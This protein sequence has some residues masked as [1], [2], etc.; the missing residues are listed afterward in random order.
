MTPVEWYYARGNKQMGPVSAPELKRLAT[1]GELR[2]ED[3]V[4][5]E[6]M[7]EW[8][9]ARNVR[10][11]F[12]EEGKPAAAVAG[13]AAAKAGES[14]LK[15][16][17]P[18]PQPPEAAAAAA[19]QGGA[20]GASSLR[21][22]AGRGPAAFQRPL[23]RGH[24]QSLSGVRLVRAAGGNGRHRGLRVDR[25]RQDRPARKSAVGGHVDLGAGGGCNTWPASSATPWT[26]SS[27]TTGGS[28]S[29]AV[30]PRLRGV[31]ERGRR[32]GGA[33]AVGCVGRRST[34]FTRS[35][36]SAWRRSWSAAFWPP[37]P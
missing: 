20:R 6:G 12:E 26:S 34:P 33:V 18:A 4:W 30:V 15:T 9:V 13:Q 7:T 22:A 8:S 28:L 24:G 31:V 16:A 32:R 17:E 36:F 35:S 23:H 19:G 1:A 21:R 27:R 14:A 11:L 10:G 37:W 2:P 29:S 25:D 3:L 5:R